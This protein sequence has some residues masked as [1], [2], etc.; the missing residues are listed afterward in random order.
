MATF[1]VLKRWRLEIEDYLRYSPRVRRWFCR[2]KA[3][4]VRRP[5]PNDPQVTARAITQL[6]G[7]ARLAYDL[8]VER[9]LQTRI[10]ELVKQLDTARLDWTEFAPNFK[11]PLIAK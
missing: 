4:R 3:W 8:Q 2:L 6:C 1:S 9:A 7:A 5:D 10:V 11:K